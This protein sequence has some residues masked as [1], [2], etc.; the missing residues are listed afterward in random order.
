MAVIAGYGVAGIGQAR[1][2]DQ[3]RLI[4]LI[5]FLEAVGDGFKV[6]E[7][8]KDL[9]SYLGFGRACSTIDNGR[10]SA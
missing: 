7:R 4:E 1:D 6:V 9:A 2:D 10:I 8:R 5:E 3:D